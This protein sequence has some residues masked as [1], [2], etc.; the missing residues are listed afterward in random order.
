MEKLSA[1]EY[2]LLKLNAE[3]LLDVIKD[4]AK[5]HHDGHFMILSFTTEYKI[6]F[7]TPS[8]SDFYQDVMSLK[9]FKDIK[10]AMIHAIL[11]QSDF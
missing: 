4:F 7:G 2:A 1:F 5:E 11:Y 6:A 9:G 3:E 10:S 8:Y